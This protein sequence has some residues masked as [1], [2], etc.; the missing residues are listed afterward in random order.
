[1]PIHTFNQ[2][3]TTTA[4][5]P[6]VSWFKFTVGA[7]GAVG[8]VSQG[9]ANLVQSVTRLGAG[10]YR[11]QFNRPYPLNVLG[12]VPVQN[13]NAV[14]DAK[15]DVDYDAGS[16][17]ATTGILDFFTSARVGSGGVQA[18]GSITCVAKASF[19]DNDTV[20]IGDGV[21]APKIYEFDFAGDGVTAGSVQVNIS[22]AT[23]AADC[24]AILKTAIEANQ[25]LF[26]VV[27]AGAGLLNLTHKLY[28][29]VGNVTITENVTDAGFL[30]TG[31]SGGTNAS[32]ANAA[33]DPAQSSELHFQLVAQAIKKLLD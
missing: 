13:R 22:G 4:K 6:V 15:V 28:G 16:Y 21:N 31:M 9:K 1:M 29:T 11:V 26:T 5:A 33:A 2:I 32:T 12:F 23:T 30:V 25:P 8:T 10:S 18:T 27:N 7:T 24:A 3:V 14:T 19:D 17:S 20:T